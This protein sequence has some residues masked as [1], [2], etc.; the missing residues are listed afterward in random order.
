MY[1]LT[2]SG[3]MSFPHYVKHETTIHTKAISYSKVYDE[4]KK[5][6]VDRPIEYR[7]T[8]E[9]IYHIMCDP[10]KL[11][12]VG[13]KFCIG[14]VAGVSYTITEIIEVRT[15]RG[16]WSALPFIQ[17][18]VRCRAE[19]NGLDRATNSVVIKKAA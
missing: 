6:Y 2:V 15:A 7:A 13:E 19:V 8:A 5:E 1:N 10:E 17:E 18:L 16:T 9:G 11:V 14:F 12:K 3:P 4:K